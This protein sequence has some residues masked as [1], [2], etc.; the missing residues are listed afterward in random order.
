M[1]LPPYAE[2]EAAAQDLAR[3]VI[4]LA[5]D[6][7]ATIAVAE[8]LTAGLVAGT[9]ASVPGASQAL[10]GGVVAYAT[11]LKAELLGVDPGLLARG[12]AVQAEVAQS[13]AAGVCA[14]LGAGFGAATTGVAGPDPQDGRPPGT[15]FVA[16]HSGSGESVLAR[17]GEQAL[18]GDRAQVRWESVRL[19]LQL[20]RD[21]LQAP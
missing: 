16:V 9:L 21:A 12:G 10:R 19:A 8:S 20:L 5:V 17:V 14:R 7:G 2:I 13:M 1:T 11:E 4:P 3:E 6:R 15:V 18:A